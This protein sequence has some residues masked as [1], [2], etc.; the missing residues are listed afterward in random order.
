MQLWVHPIPVGSKCKSSFWGL[1]RWEEIGRQSS[2][3]SGVAL[4]VLPVVAR[5]GLHFVS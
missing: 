2:E 1:W 5:E 3:G 4:Q